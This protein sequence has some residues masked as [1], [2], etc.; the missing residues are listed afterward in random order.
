LSSAQADE[1]R[2]QLR[3]VEELARFCRQTNQGF[4]NFDHAAR[5]LPKS[6]RL[7]RQTLGQMDGT[8]RGLQFCLQLMF[9][10]RHALV[11]ERL[12]FLI[13]PVDQLIATEPPLSLH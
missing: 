2:V 3:V 7:G 4:Q 11:V 5:K 10:V 8:G 1:R 13:K 12:D 6:N 9:K